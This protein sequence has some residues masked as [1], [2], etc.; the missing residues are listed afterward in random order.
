MMHKNGLIQAKTSKIHS[1]GDTPS[2]F[3]T[4]P[5]LVCE[6]EPKI[7]SSGDRKKTPNYSKKVRFDAN[8]SNFKRGKRKLARFGAER[9]A[10][11]A[12]KSVF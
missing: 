4:H 2:H 10:K 12:E 5:P 1:D 8:P 7:G 3:D 9:N 11:F 6:T